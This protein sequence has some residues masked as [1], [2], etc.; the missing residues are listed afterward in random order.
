MWLPF[1]FLLYFFP[2]LK[3]GKVIFEGAQKTSPLQDQDKQLSVFL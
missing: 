1:K 3:K 2:A